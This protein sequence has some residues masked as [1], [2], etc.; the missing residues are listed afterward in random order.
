MIQEHQQQNIKYPVATRL[1]NKLW[2]SNPQSSPHKTQRIFWIMQ[3]KQPTG[4]NSGK[5][6]KS[7][8]GASKINLAAC[9]TAASFL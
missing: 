4:A 6:Y 1:V 7:A 9:R 8:W 2:T 3:Y 5:T